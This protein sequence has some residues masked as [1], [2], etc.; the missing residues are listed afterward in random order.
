MN[1]QIQLRIKR[2]MDIALSS[3]ALVLLCIPFAVIAVL[4]RLDSPGPVFF[5]Q[6]RLGKHEKPFRIW[7]FRT[8]VEN[9]QNQGLGL[10]ATKD[11]FRITR[12]GSILR[13][14]GADELPQVINVFTGEMSIVGPRPAICYPVKQYDDFYRRRFQV[15]P[16]VTCLAIVKGR[17][18]LP[19]EER[20]RLD[21]EYIDN[22]SLWQDFIIILETFWVVLVTHKGVYGPGGVNDGGFALPD[23]V[24]ISESE[25]EYRFMGAQASSLAVKSGEGSQVR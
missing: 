16:G 13:K 9:A 19:W 14:W 7:K 3:I 21:V 6:E 17:N 5:R 10:N 1:K 24:G 22:W 18:S 12:A 20:I 15:R 2:A 25:S 11:D 23:T 4:I 8:M